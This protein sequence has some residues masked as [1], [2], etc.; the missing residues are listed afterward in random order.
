MEGDCPSLP[1]EPQ[2]PGLKGYLLHTHK[3]ISSDP[4]THMKTKGSHLPGTPALLAGAQMGGLW[5][6]ASS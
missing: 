6:F 5:A 2:E 3:D 1:A 4:S